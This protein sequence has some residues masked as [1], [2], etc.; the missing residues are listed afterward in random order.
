M[1]GQLNL[2]ESRRSD[3]TEHS[4][5]RGDRPP[6]DGEQQQGEGDHRAV[7]ARGERTPR[8]GAS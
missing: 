6:G 1:R 5:W 2:A 3:E 7:R 8:D 4:F